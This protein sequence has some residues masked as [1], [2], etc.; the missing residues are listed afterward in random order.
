MGHSTSPHIAHV[1][2]VALK[3]SDF[4]KATQL[5]SW[6]HCDLNQSLPAQHW[7]YQLL[8]RGTMPLSSVTTASPP[9]LQSLFSL[10]HPLFKTAALKLPATQAQYQL[11]TCISILF[12]ARMKSKAWIPDAEFLSICFCPRLHL[13]PPS[14]VME[15]ESRLPNIWH[16]SVSDWP[17]IML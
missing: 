3:L 7:Y 10:S 14:D 12:S 11:W 15:L 9:V 5:F 16:E 13:Q 8:F 1:E 4:L 2:W 17:A 6:L